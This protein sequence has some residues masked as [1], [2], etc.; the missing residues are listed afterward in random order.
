V[1]GGDATLCQITFATCLCIH[2]H[3]Q[4]VDT[5]G[6][7]TGTASG[8][9]KPALFIRKCSLLA[10]ETEKNQL[11]QVQLENGDGDGRHLHFDNDASSM[12]ATS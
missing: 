3:F 12:K 1:C 9:Y 5:V 7:V 10:Q 8:L 11:S 6:W 4:R 2:L